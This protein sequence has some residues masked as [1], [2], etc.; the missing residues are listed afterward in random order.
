[1]N[2]IKLADQVFVRLH[3]KRYCP[4]GVELFHVNGR[5]DGWIQMTKLVV[6][7]GN[8]ANTPKTLVPTTAED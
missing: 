6:V 3:F 4:M 8:S 7:F 2:S 5:T 1:M